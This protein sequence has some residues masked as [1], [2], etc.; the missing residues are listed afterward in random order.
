VGILNLTISPDDI[1]EDLIDFP[2][3]VKLSTAVGKNSF[4]VS[5]LFTALGE[6][7]LKFKIETLVSDVLTESPVEIELWDST[8]NLAILHVKVPMISS[9]VETVLKLTY[10]EAMDDNTTY[11][12]VTETPAAK[13]V[14]DDNFVAVY[15]MAQDPS[16]GGACVLDSTSNANH[17]TPDGAMTFGDLVDDGFG[18][19]L[20][21][22]GVDDYISIPDGA[23][24]SG[25]SARTISVSLTPSD[26]SAYKMFFSY[27]GT[28]DNT[29]Y[30][31]EIGRTIDGKL[32][33]NYDSNVDSE[34]GA[35]IQLNVNQIVTLIYT[36]TQSRALVDNLEVI[37]ATNTINTT[38]SNGGIGKR[39][40][41]T[42]YPYIGTIS[43]VR[44]SNIVRSDS[45]IKATSDGLADLLIT[46]DT[47]P[48]Y[49]V[50]G[51][52]KEEGVAVARVISLLSRLTPA[53]IETIESESDGSF[54]FTGLETD[55]DVTLI[56]FDDAAGTVYNDR[57][58]RVTPMEA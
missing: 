21:F 16:T 25:A 36:G 52:I 49:K 20:S 53:I 45:W 33:L 2:L 38:A 28:S 7:K 14:W 22:D 26:V 9:T 34:S 8:N 47:V 48:T 5:A 41:S 46:F 19:A 24:I 13:T 54:E 4:D 31:G 44:I 51:V 3:P 57:I 39:T 56:V 43:D 42:A 55:D 17:G 10:S 27:G 58:V 40:V 32:S 30:T 11:V 15:L 18:K 35:S 50:T 37:N 1:A 29:N 23:L 6:N 12:G